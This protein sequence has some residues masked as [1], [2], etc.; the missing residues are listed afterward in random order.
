MRRK[1]TAVIIVRSQK[2]HSHFVAL[3][4]KA[5]KRG[6]KYGERITNPAQMLI[7]RLPPVLKKF[8]LRK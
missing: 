5:V 4:I 6:P 2:P 1:Q 3:R 8:G 7:L